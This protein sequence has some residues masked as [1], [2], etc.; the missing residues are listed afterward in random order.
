MSW[1]IYLD[2][3]IC[4]EKFAKLQFWVSLVEIKMLMFN[5]M[6]QSYF[7]FAVKVG[8]LYKTW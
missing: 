8:V 5:S 2:K 7:F 1:F 6:C 4:T 3:Q